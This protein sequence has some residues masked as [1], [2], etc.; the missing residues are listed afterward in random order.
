MPAEPPNYQNVTLDKSTEDAISGLFG[1]AEPPKPAEPAPEPKPEPAKEPE[2]PAEAAKPD[3]AKEPEKTTPDDPIGDLIKPKEKPAEAA[4]PA[5]PTEDDGPKDPKQLRHAYKSARGELNSLK[6]KYTTL[7]NDVKNARAELEK[8]KS[9][10]ASVAELTALKKDLEDARERVR[11]LDF[12]KSPD[13]DTGYVKP[14]TAAYESAFNTLVDQPYE[15]PDGSQAQVTQQDV[16]DLVRAPAIQAAKV[17]AKLFGHAAPV[18]LQQRQSIIDLEAKRDAAKT[19]WA[20]K[21]QTW[22]QEQQRQQQENQ[23]FILDTFDGQVSKFSELAKDVFDKPE[24]AKLAARWE[25]GNR[26]VQLAFKQSG[27]DPALAW[28]DRTKILTEAQGTVAAYARAFPMVLDRLKASEAQI[29]DLNAKLKGFQ[30]SEP[31]VGHQGAAKDKPAKPDAGKDY[32]MDG[33][34]EFAKRR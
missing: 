4:K 29:A 14:L 3:P 12:E 31:S 5:E 11:L 1:Q 25:A 28:K 21:G 23:K 2:K 9:E 15:N 7:E 27:L 8:A 24:D 18:A 16:I 26:L 10:G 19:E 20:N 6:A 34:T 22:Q 17:A 33:L 30:K 13:F 32:I